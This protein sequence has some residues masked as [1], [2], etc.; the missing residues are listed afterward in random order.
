[1]SS[2]EKDSFCSYC[3]TKFTTAYLSYPKTCDE[4]KK[5]TYNNPKLVIAILQPIRKDGRVGLLV[6]RRG[7]SLGAGK[8]GLP[9]GFIE[10][11][12]TAEQA[13][14]RETLEEVGL[15]VDPIDLYL[16]E[17]SVV[18]TSVAGNL[19]LFARNTRSLIYEKIKSSLCLT[20]EASEIGLIHEVTNEITETF[21]FPSHV[22]A[23]KKWCAEFQISNYSNRPAYEKL[24]G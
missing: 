1:M 24:L 5:P 12:E 8:F 17:N 23:I 16:M 9:G 19:I 14:T 18:S 6:L 2:L 13:G 22:E 15:T 7:R 3:G 4:C 10:V 21:A 20:S 11:N